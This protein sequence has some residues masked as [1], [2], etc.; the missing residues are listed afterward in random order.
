MEMQTLII[1]EY[2][3]Y[4]IGSRRRF[5]S[6]MAAPLLQGHCRCLGFCGF[7][8]KPTAAL[9]NRRERNK[10]IL[11][12]H[13]LIYSQLITVANVISSLDSF[14]SAQFDISRTILL[15]LFIFFL[16]SAVYISCINR[17]SSRQLLGN[18]IC[19]SS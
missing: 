19:I 12:F 16:P 9:P 3:D 15:V 10:I 2:I 4:I 5:C 6:H 7:T 18:L 1:D 11:A 14:F 17:L 13:S 8:D